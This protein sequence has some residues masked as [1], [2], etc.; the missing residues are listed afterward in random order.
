MDLYFISV[1]AFFAVLAILLIV[2]R[3]NIEVNN[4]VLFMR[5]TQR[6]RGIIERIAS[7]NESFWNKIGT[8]SSIVG[9]AGM[10]FAFVF[11]GYVFSQQLVGPPTAEGPA[12]VLPSP[13]GDT[14]A[15]PGVIAVP[16]WEWIIAILVLVIVHEGMHGI[17]VKNVKSNIKSLGLA[18]FAVIPGAFVEPDE[19]DLNQKSW[20]DQ[21]KVYSAGSFGNFG[22]A[23][24]VIL[25][26]NFAFLPAFTIQ[27]VG[28]VGYVNAT[29]YGMESFP[30]EEVNLTSPIMSMSGQ[31]TRS[32]DEF[33]EIMDRYEPGDEI[34]V[35]TMESNFTFSLAENPD[36]PGEPFMGISGVS[37]TYVLKGRYRNTRA[38]STLDFLRNL[39]SWMFVLN[40][41]I[42]IM[43]LLPLKPLDGGL[44]LESLSEKF[45]PKKSEDIVRVV[46]GLSL[47]MLLMTLAISF[48]V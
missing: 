35:E 45:Y 15:R 29:E 39:F 32:F 12:L 10:V 22:M 28:F 40:L 47:L 13:R 31:R 38:G 5:R 14:V 36:N 4:Y 46:S 23:L 6:G 19:E 16:F 3:K 43:N 1:I 21:I 42:G 9:I 7:W 24:L 2:D 27:S 44:I 41:G 48:M 20:K 17:M 37:E 33:L 30:A 25:F 26:M 11:I 8:V 18:L 34:T